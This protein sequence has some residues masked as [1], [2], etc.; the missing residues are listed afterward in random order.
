[1]TLE[2]PIRRLYIRPSREAPTI[3]PLK[4]YL[5]TIIND[6]RKSFI[7]TQQQQKTSKTQTPLTTLPAPRNHHSI[8][9][10]SPPS[11]AP[12]APAPS[13]PPPSPST[14]TGISPRAC[15]T[16]TA[17]Q[18]LPPL[19]A[20]LNPSQL[21]L[22]QRIRKLRFWDRRGDRRSRGVGR[23]KRRERRVR[24]DLLLGRRIGKEGG[25]NGLRW[26]CVEVGFC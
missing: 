18:L 26:G 10:P 5:W 22:R 23:R 21:C 2:L 20:A 24:G 1:M 4:Q 6:T 12:S 14:K 19:P 3:P 11:S 25:D 8:N 15:R 13:P 17:A 16:P 9:N 7:P